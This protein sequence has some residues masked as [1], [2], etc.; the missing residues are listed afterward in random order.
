MGQEGSPRITFRAPES[1]KEHEAVNPHTPSHCESWSPKWTP[2]SSESD[3]R[4]Q[5]PLV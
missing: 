1:A 3:F 2:K 5:N 4:G